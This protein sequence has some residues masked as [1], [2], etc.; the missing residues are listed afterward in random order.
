M[1][2]A[3]YRSAVRSRRLIKTA[4]A[5]LL[6]EKSLDKITVTDVVQRAEINRGTFYA[7]YRDISDVLDQIIDETFFHIRD[8]LF[9]QPHNIEAVP[10]V[11]LT[12]VQ[13]I[14][15]EDVDLYKKIVNS[16]AF[17]LLQEQLVRL[18]L[19]F[20]FQHEENFALGSHEQYALL[21]RFCAGGLTELYA[22]W[23]AG[24]L[25][26]TLSELTAHAET[27]VRSIITP[28]VAARPQK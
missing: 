28:V 25:P 19:D 9:A 27:L 23:F 1:P 21:M 24:K 5:D 8:A 2:K 3:E 20:L 11:L 26:F 4:L 14:L 7:H 17:P 6:L 13:A 22:A 18:V 10:H 16:G 12:R 15:E